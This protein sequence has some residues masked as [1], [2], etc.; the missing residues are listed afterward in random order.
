MQD[1]VRIR[2]EFRIK[3]VLVYRISFLF[4]LCATTCTATVC[5]R[6]NSKSFICDLFSMSSYCRHASRLILW[7]RVNK[8]V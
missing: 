5:F 7:V 2:G 1:N 6:L 4:S 3:R 8:K